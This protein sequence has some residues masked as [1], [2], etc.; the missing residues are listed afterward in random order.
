MSKKNMDAPINIESSIN[1]NQERNCLS[2]CAYSFQYNTSSCNAYH[3]KDHIRIPYDSPSGV[4]PARFNGVN[5]K[6]DHIHIY[7]PSLHRY[8][9]AKAD[10]ELL[11]YHSSA[12]GRNLIVCIPINLGSGGGKQSSD[13]MNN[14]LQNLPEKNS[15]SGKYIAD[16]TNFNL[17]NLIPKEG[18]YTYVGRHLLPQYTGVYN[19]IVYHKVHAIQVFRDS[20]KSLTDASVSTSI[21]ATSTPVILPKNMYFYNKKGANKASAGDDIYIKCN[22]TGEDGTVLYQQSAGSNGLPGGLSDLDTSKSGL[23]WN[24]IMQSDIFKKMVGVFLGITVGIIMFF[25]FRFLYNRMG[26]ASPEQAAQ[27]GGSSSFRRTST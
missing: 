16:V 23:D 10:A 13:I 2:T 4:Y 15:G 18:F 9:G 11:A 22:P 19:Y 20:I 17:G 14:I 5:F 21:T 6:V 1:S 26:G 27:S 7:Q 8:E 24:K 3:E 25:G 12:D